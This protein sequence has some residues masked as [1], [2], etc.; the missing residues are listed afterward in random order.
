[1]VQPPLLLVE[2]PVVY[3]PSTEW[4]AVVSGETA[5]FS[6]ADGTMVLADA[7]LTQTMPTVPMT[8]AVAM[9]PAGLLEQ[10]AWEALAYGEDFRAEELFA[11]VL[12]EEPDNARAR[13]GYGLA[14]ALM[15]RD[16]TAA[17]ALRDALALRLDVLDA[18]PLPSGTRWRLTELARS[19]ENRASESPSGGADLYFLAAALRASVG[20]R[21]QAVY[22]MELAAR[23]G[24]LD[25]VR[26]NFLTVLSSQIAWRP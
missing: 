10:N 1:M 26:G 18:L 9:P 4:I 2:Q 16:A 23:R 7:S 17:W 8:P 11:G 14:A 12:N 6:A 25:E 19:I 20:D 3:S 13:A 24:P 15:G 5:P 22:A 21:A